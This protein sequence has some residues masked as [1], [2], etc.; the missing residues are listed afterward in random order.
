L[1]LASLGVIVSFVVAAVLGPVLYTAIS[2]TSAVYLC[3]FSTNLHM[4]LL[5]TG[6]GQTSIASALFYLPLGTKMSKYF[7]WATKP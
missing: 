5:S 6:L 7:S 2:Q 3:V 4:D 1:V